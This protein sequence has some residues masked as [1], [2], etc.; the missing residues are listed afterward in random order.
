M[1][2]GPTVQD[3]NVYYV[4]QDLLKVEMPSG[5]DLI[6]FLTGF[7]IVQRIDYVR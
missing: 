2:S 4:H 7:Y 6:L 5:I 3:T 1:E